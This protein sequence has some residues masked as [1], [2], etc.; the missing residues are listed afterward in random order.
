MTQT[1]ASR[2]AALEAK[3]AELSARKAELQAEMNTLTARIDAYNMELAQRFLAESIEN[4]KDQEVPAET[5][6]DFR[7]LAAS[8]F[9][10]EGTPMSFDG[11]FDALF[12]LT[13]ED[14]YSFFYRLILTTL[15]EVK[16]AVE[17]ND[18]SR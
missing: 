7:D 17:A 15:D 9:L 3:I 13:R 18:Y 2:E 16:A 10:P 14:R 6:S 5:A 12:A 1:T 4:L 8:A 11:L